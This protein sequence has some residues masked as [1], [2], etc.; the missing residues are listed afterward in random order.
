MS[1]RLTYYIGK[2]NKVLFVDKKVKADG[3]AQAIAKKLEELGVQK[4]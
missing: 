3:H 4:N 1:N 2:D